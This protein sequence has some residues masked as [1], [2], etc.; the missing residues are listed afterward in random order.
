M[1]TLRRLREEDGFTIVEAMVAVT[2]LAVGISLT[3]QPVMASLRRIADAR[4]I[5]VAENLAQAEIES[6][7]ALS[8]ADVGL[9]GRTP[10]GVLDAFHEVT[11][12]GRV[13][14]VEVDVRYAG[15]LTGL[16]VIPQGGDGV[17]GAW[18]PGVDYKVVKVTVTAEGRESDPVVMETIVSPGSVGA[19][20]GIANARV[21]LAAY[22]PFASSTHDLP[23]LKIQASPAAPIASALYADQQVFPAIPPADYTVTL[24]DADGWIIHP[25]DVLTGADRLH[26]TAGTLAETTLRVYRPATLL[27]T[28][29]DY[30]TGLPVIAPRLAYKNLVSL[31]TIT[32]ASG[33]L[34]ATG[35]IPDAYDLMV[36]ASGYET[37]TL[38]SVN[39]PGNY[40]D[41]VHNLTVRMQPIGSSTTTTTTTTIASTTT[42]T[43]AGATTTTTVAATTTTTTIPANSRLVTF[44]V[45]DS[46]GRVVNGATVTI[47]RPGYPTIVVTTDDHGQASYNLVRNV[48]YTANA[49]TAWGHGSVSKTLDPDRVSALELKM[50]RP[51][52]KGTL[53]LQSGDNAE[54]LYRPSGDG[55]WTVLPANYQ[56]EASFVGSPGQYD[57]AKR[58]L[59]TGAVLGQKTVSVSKNKNVS[60]SISGWCP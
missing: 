54:F 10:S 38:S 14:S 50:T 59:A 25:D 13:Y 2:I 43:Q 31:Q 8:Y 11:V 18:D 3:I 29:V 41:P 23:S 22:E 9:P 7:R 45:K 24:D 57:V 39:I 19:H 42:T 47:T 4:T 46:S 52:G 49:S 33:V 16:D 53:I 21:Y 26:V 30:S 1:T 58:C 34:T 6:L 17:E 51:S 37:W 60:T 35:L 15:S 40:P 56:D 36:T 48:T 27:L 5:S 12:E 44:T 28:V 55:A 32:L 20:E